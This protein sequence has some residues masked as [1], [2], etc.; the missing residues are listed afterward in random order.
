MRINFEDRSV[1][2]NQFLDDVARKVAHMVWKSIKKDMEKE[3][4]MVTTEEAAKILGI[5]PGRMRRIKDRFPHLKAGDSTRGRLLF[6]RD[7]LLN[8]YAR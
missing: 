4:E 2:Y 8:E 3:P 5:S 7:A 6:K 1:T